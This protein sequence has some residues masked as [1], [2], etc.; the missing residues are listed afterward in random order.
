MLDNFEDYSSEEESTMLDV[1]AIVGAGTI[2]GSTE[3]DWENESE[4]SEDEF[5]S[6]LDDESDGEEGFSPVMKQILA[7]CKSRYHIWLERA[8]KGIS[9]DMYDDQLNTYNKKF[10]LSDES[11]S[12]DGGSPNHTGIVHGCNA[13]YASLW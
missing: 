6:P 11:L 1:E 10:L 9:F 3:D 8:H 7:F 4:V 2:Q 5:H 12:I 13:F